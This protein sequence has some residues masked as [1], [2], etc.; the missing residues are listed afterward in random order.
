MS[1]VGPAGGLRYHLRAARHARALW[2]PFRDQIGAWL[3]D[4]AAGAAPAGTPLLLVG[5][6]AAYCLP[7]A[8]LAGR[9]IVGLEPDPLARWLL[10]RRLRRLGSTA[11]FVS[12]DL[13]VAPV[14]AQEGRGAAPLRA[15]LEA[16]PE[17]ALL[18]CNFLGQLHLLVDE[19]QTERLL[20]AWRSALGG[21]L[22]GRRWA[23][24]HDR[25]S[26]DV[27]P[28]G[29]LPY[30]AA[31]R[32][33]DEALL[34]RLYPASSPSPGALLDHHTEGLFD[35]ALP[36]TYFSWRLTPSTTHLIEAVAGP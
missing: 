35:A 16:H 6:S 4:W 19:T 33:D 18:F 8:L 21:L 17:A 13:F 30:R 24:L 10:E 26:G 29:P 11:K 1:L 23:S 15:L 7:D 2:Q 31:E 12:E 28:V 14:L 27:A 32:L 34:E 5:P 9:R 22:R 20:G 3:L 36:H 25:V